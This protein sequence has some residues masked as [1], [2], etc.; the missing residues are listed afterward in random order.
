MRDCSTLG[1]KQIFTTWSNPK[2]NSD[3]ER[4]M[5]TIKEDIVWPCDWD[6]PFEFE[7]ALTKWIE[8]YNTDFPHQALRNL[9]PRQFY[10]N[11]VVNEQSN[12]SLKPASYAN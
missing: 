5:R 6:N 9:T 11:F 2:G 1:I 3:A 4:V 10:E 8:S 12:L 7:A